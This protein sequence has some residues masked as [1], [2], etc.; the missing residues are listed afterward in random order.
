MGFRGGMWLDVNYYNWNFVRYPSLLGLWIFCEIYYRNCN[1]MQPSPSFSVRVWPI[2]FPD[3]R[4]SIRLSCRK[5]AFW[6]KE[7][8]VVQSK[9]HFLNYWVTQPVYYLI[10]INYSSLKK[11]WLQIVYTQIKAVFTTWKRFK[12]AQK[13]FCFVRFDNKGGW[14]ALILRQIFNR[15]PV[16]NRNQLIDLQS[17][18]IDWF[19]YDVKIGLD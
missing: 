13:F 4:A 5:K 12:I 18:S 7:G 10:F 9:K 14:W 3:N 2:K 6:K 1:G 8:Q 19:L 11:S 15:R 17:K 16:Y